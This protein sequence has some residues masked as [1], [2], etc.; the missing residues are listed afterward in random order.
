[1]YRDTIF[2]YVKKQYGTIPEYLWNDL[3]DSAILRNDNGKWY[4]VFMNLEGFK[5]G[6]DTKDRVDIMV[7][8]CKPDMISV[9]T[10]MKGFLPGYYMDKSKLDDN[11]SA[12]AD[13]MIHST[14]M[15]EQ[16]SHQIENFKN[17]VDV[18]VKEMQ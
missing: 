9:M 3:P 5:I 18:R 8:K 17:T 12:T 6:L 4:A 13:F 16:Y 1:M 7:V 10:H 11:S 15:N 2:Q 14:L